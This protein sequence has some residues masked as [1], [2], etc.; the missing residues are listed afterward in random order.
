MIPFVFN[1]FKGITGVWKKN[2]SCSLKTDCMPETTK[3]VEL[4]ERDAVFMSRQRAEIVVVLFHHVFW[5]MTKL[6]FTEHLPD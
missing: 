3:V 6:P 1:Q 2:R 4:M 5:R